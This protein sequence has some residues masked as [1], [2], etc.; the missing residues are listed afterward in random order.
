M[1]LVIVIF[2]LIAAALI[3]RIISGTKRDVLAETKR[4]VRS[5]RNEVLGKAKATNCTLPSATWFDTTVAH[6]LGRSA[7]ES[8]LY[9][10]A[11]RTLTLVNGTNQIAAFVIASNGTDRKNDTDYTANPSDLRN[12]RDDVVDFATSSYVQSLCP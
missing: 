5:A 10:N 6:R 12:V 2:G 3:P 11:T 8:L 1:A 4:A 9:I 7:A